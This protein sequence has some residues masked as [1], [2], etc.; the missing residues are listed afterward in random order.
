VISVIIPTYNER[1]NLEELFRRIHEALTGVSDYEIIVVD[2]N[3]PDGT[4]EEARRLS[5]RYPVKVLV[6]PGKLGLSSAVMDGLKLA[7]GDLIAVMDADLQHPP[8]LL[9][10]LYRRIEEGCDIA[11]ASRYVRGGSVANWS[12][13]RKIISKGSILLAWI[14]LPRVRWVRDPASGY[15]M[16][17]REVIEGRDLNP[18]GFKILMEILVKGN[19]SRICEVPYTFGLRRRG[20]SK[21]G[22]K[23]IMSY[24]LHVLELS[25]PIVRFAIVGAVGTLVNLGVLWFLRYAMDVIHEVAS[26]IAIEVSL[27][28]NFVLNDI[29]TFRKRRRAGIAQSVIRYHLANMAGILTQYSVS[30]ALFRLVSL[31]SLLSQFIGI[32]VGFLVNYFLSKRIVWWS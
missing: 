15:F 19:Y 4:A 30:V 22:T 20:V 14:L 7:N 6:R 16:L 28:S 32:L 5:F 27:L 13:T 21:L 8:E 17:R 31:E 10:E 26:A 29:W 3:S 12:F 18:R 2:D 1:D 11:I 23:V 9:P 25:P 24:I